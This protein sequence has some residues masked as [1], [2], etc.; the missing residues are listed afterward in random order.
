MSRS[1]NASSAENRP[2]PVHGNGS[3]ATHANGSNSVSGPVRLNSWK[4]IAAYLDRDS[5][6]VQLWEKYEGLPVHRHMHRTKASVY[7]YRDEIDA[8][9]RGRSG[10]GGGIV[11]SMTQAVRKTLFGR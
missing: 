2:G 4:S 3:G 5:R 8:W 10:E 1:K 7:A 11:V 9:L 6:T